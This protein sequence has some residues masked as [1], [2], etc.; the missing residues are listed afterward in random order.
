MPLSNRVVCGLAALAAAAALG[1][2][3]ASE[4]WGDLVPCAL[5]L[6]E[7]VPYKALIA[8]GVVGFLLPTGR[9]LVLWLILLSALAAVALACVHVGVE[10]RF[11]P[12]P[13]P[14]CTATLVHAGTI[15]ERLAALP[16]R[17]ARPCDDPSYLIPWLPIS[18]AA[19][20]LLFSL[21]FAALVAIYLLNPRRPL[22]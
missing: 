14:E 11:W 18:M 22:P 20:N 2:A 1:I 17:P 8:L 5:C 16:A 15:A 6:W 19:M 21:V 9:K 4:R 3:L 12:S 7:R 10:L 13:L